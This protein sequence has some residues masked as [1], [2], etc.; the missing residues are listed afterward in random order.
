M[1]SRSKY[2]RKHTQQLEQKVEKQPQSPLFDEIFTNSYDFI[3]RF[4]SQDT[5]T[6]IQIVHILYN[7]VKNE[8]GMSAQ[9]RGNFYAEEARYLLS[10]IHKL[11]H[12]SYDRDVFYPLAREEKRLIRMECYGTINGRKDD[13]LSYLFKYFRKNAK[14]GKYPTTSYR[15]MASPSW[16]V[17]H[18]FETFRSI[19]KD[20]RKNLQNM[21]IHPDALQVMTVNDFCEVI[22]Q[23]YKTDNSATSA[24]FLP[25]HECL[26]NRQ[27]RAVMKYAGAEFEAMLMQREVN[28]KKIDERVVKSF[29]DMMRRYG[30]DDIG[31]L[32]VTER[33]Y[34]KR[35]LEGLAREELTCFGID[36]S[37]LEEGMPIAQEFID[38][39]VDN[40]K[41]ELIMARDE[42][43]RPLSKE[44][45]PRMEDHHN[46]N[47]MLAGKGD[48]I[49]AANYP[50]NHI[51]V[52]S[53]IHQGYLHWLGKTVKSGD[54]VELI[55]ARLNA[56]DSK[57]RVLFGF[58]A[59]KDAIYCDLENNAEFRR[60]KIK[61]LKCKINYFDMMQIR[62]QNEAKIIERHNINCS[63]SYIR[64]GYRNLKEIKNTEEYNKE[65][66]K[67]VEKL[68]KQ[69]HIAKK[70]GKGR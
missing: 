12:F 66:M 31:S 5:D 42:K 34:T 13:E 14:P 32:V 6:Q 41:A 60:R 63:R 23:S 45:L 29:C 3:N 65:A 50:N 35:I 69:Q 39:M 59:E 53:R 67:M 26:K 11:A 49:V 68:L 15:L 16:K 9:K 2:S 18:Q 19:E 54:G 40:N 44:G 56:Q 61:D 70:K 28:G 48:T 51:S 33:K 1:M 58:D 47:V 21:G 17:F 37:Q 36:V 38:Y 46:L 4:K 30:S 25:K 8:D 20:M 57:M 22:F 43:G 7:I 64:E 52:D 24:N 62:M 10:S 27:N 55:Y